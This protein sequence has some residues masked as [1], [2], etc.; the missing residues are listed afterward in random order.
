MALAF[1]VN[2][3]PGAFTALQA[4]NDTNRQLTTTQNRL[5]TGLA[6][7][8]ASDDAAT[9]AIAQ[10]LR[11][12]VGGL[13][14]VQGS[15]DRSISAV[16]VA[17]NASESISE[18]LISLRETATSAADPGLDADSR[19]SLQDEFSQVLAQI[20][21]IVESAAFNGTNLISAANSV[22]AIDTDGAAVF[23][24]SGADLSGITGTIQSTF[25]SAAS[26]AATLGRIDTVSDTVNG[27]LSDLGAGQNR[28]ELQQT[29]ISK[30]SDT[31]EVGIGNLV[32]ADL[33]KESARLQSLQVKQQ[34][35]LQ[36]LGIANQAPQAV[37]ALFG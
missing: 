12:T 13:N 29:F 18:L 28:L 27:L 1:S 14:A 10:N 33:A 15:L 26:A 6:V 37:M 7:A 32:D 19:S 24:V 20:D 2:T 25:A 4:L 3:N 36:A 5:N 16:D 35:G 23:S 17:L 9:F 21:S 8:G 22:V 31:L 11:A 34:L 30:L